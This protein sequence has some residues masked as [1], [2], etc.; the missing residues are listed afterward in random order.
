MKRT[1]H[2]YEAYMSWRVTR[3]GRKWQGWEVMDPARMY[4][5]FKLEHRWV[6]KNQKEEMEAIMDI[7]LKQRARASL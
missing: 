3:N 7:L 4:E 5:M 2:F 6:D 1:P